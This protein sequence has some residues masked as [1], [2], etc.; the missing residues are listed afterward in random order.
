M[1]FMTFIMFN[2]YKKKNHFSFCIYC[3]ILN[4]PY[5][6]FYMNHDSDVDMKQYISSKKDEKQT[7][8]R[9]IIRPP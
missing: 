5:C 9:E 8:T 2:K 6:V 4:I 1:S 3:F 7:F